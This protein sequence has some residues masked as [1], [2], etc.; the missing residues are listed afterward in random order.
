MILEIEQLTA[1]WCFF[2][3]LLLGKPKTLNPMSM[4]AGGRYVYEIFQYFQA[5]VTNLSNYEQFLQ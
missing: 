3:L 5:F 1:V 4:I 2:F